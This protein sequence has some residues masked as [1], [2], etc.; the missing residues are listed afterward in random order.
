MKSV[1]FSLLITVALVLLVVTQSQSQFVKTLGG[2]SEEL[3]GSLIQ[4]S[5]SGFVMTGRTEGCL[6][7][8][9]ALHLA[10]FD[11]FGNHLWTKALGEYG[12]DW[13]K[14]VTETSD[15]GLAVTGF[16][17]SFGA[18]EGDLLLVK[19]DSSGDTIW[20]KTLGGNSSD[21]GECVIQTSDGGLVVSGWTRSFGPGFED[22]LL[23]KFDSSG[24]HLWTRTLEGSFDGGGRCVIQASDGGL[25]V[26]GTTESFGA[27]GDDLVLTKFDASGNYLWTRTLGG[28][29]LDWGRFVIQASDGGLVVTGY[30]DSFGAG[31]YDLL[32][33]KFDAC[34]N[35]LWT[36]TLGG[37]GKEK[38]FSVTE[39]YDGGL[40]VTGRT[41]SFAVGNLLLAK[42]DA[43]G[44]H[45]W[46][47]VI[48]GGGSDYG[49]SVIQLSDG[50]LVAA[51]YTTS[52]G[53]GDYDLLLA[54]FGSLGNTCLGEFVTPTVQNVSPTITSP[55][56]TMISPSPTI[57]SPSPW[58]A[59]DHPAI[60]L[61]CDDRIPRIL[62]ITDVGNDQGK[63]V[64]VKWQCC[65][66][67]SAS[68]PVTITE[69]S[70]WRRTDK[71]KFHN[72]RE[73]I[74]SYGSRTVATDPPIQLPGWELIKTVPATGEST[75]TS[76]CST[77]VDSTEVGGMYWSVFFVR[78]MTPD[79]LIYF[80]S[81]PDSGYSLDNIPPLPI[82][83]LEIDPSSWFTLQWTVP[84]EYPEEQPISAYDIRYN[85]VPIGAD[86][87]AWWDNA[88]VC[89][90]EGF[91][92]L[93]VGDTDSLK[94]A[95]ET[96]CHPECYFAIKGLDSRPNA[97]GI[98]NIVHFMCGDVN[99]DGVVELGDIVY[100]INYVFRNGPPPVPGAVGDVTCDGVVELGD[101]VY[102]INYV[103]RD[104]PPPC[105]Q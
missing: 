40:V 30:T 98:S 48:G 82:Q 38:G 3:V 63:Q 17:D 104:G 52:F 29:G 76:I 24:N 86:T 32:L 72:R 8:V 83:D 55:T 11:A 16:T 88:E 103:F 59:F 50:R 53:A 94:V 74:L 87:Q 58:L 73:E 64:R 69:Y 81:D 2:I 68:S 65:Y 62:S 42:F 100:E 46:T 18:G 85:T 34:G 21:A 25:V 90:G 45:L 35:H 19:F 97:S 95:Q 7:G 23:A 105:S 66:Y 71:D 13:G 26:I 51:G 102:L 4:T 67:D 12:Q 20:T 60:I 33:A 57:T 39:T 43:S 6:A 70:I 84:G 75:Y 36:K 101:V 31:N 22:F 14:S 56:P 80:D 15:G 1:R 93:I 92:N 79:T 28:N 10:K 9:Y 91:F 77:L 37:S 54:T 78:A 44:N 89:A 96:W 99:G 61:V 41:E 27:G 49:R 47:R 5:D